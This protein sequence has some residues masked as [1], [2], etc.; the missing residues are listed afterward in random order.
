M[1]PLALDN[2]S[3]LPP[4]E[5]AA[6]VGCAVGDVVCGLPAIGAFA[7]RG[8]LAAGQAASPLAGQGAANRA[9]GQQEQ[10]NAGDVASGQRTFPS[11]TDASRD[12]DGSAS[13]GWNPS[14]SQGDQAAGKEQTTS[15]EEKDC[16]SDAAAATVDLSAAAVAAQTGGFPFA[17]AKANAKGVAAGQTAAPGASAKGVLGSAKTPPSDFA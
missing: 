11:K 13:Q 16:G 4:Q 9:S 3:S 6:V 12:Q 17:A 8:R 15:R 7:R 2:L 10:N 1:L 14:G 5:S